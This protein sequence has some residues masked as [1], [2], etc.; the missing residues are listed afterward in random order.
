MASVFDNHAVSSS[1]DGAKALDQH[2]DRG[3]TTGIR[4]LESAIQPIIRPATRCMISD[5]TPAL[6][7]IGATR[8]ADADRFGTYNITRSET[9]MAQVR[10]PIRN[11]LRTKPQSGRSSIAERAYDMRGFVLSMP[12]ITRSPPSAADPYPLSLMAMPADI[13]PVLTRGAPI[14]MTVTAMP[15]GD[16]SVSLRILRLHLLRHRGDG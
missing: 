8:H 4:T 15:A 10:F 3:M 14:A 1:R 13:M 2:I 6:Q 7:R 5:P 11:G 12:S 9:F 16:H